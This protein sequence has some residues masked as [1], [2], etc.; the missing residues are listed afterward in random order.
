MSGTDA[1]KSACN[2][3]RHRKI[4]CDRAKPACENCR[5]AGVACLFTAL[6]QRKSPREQLEEAKAQIKQLKETLRLERAGQH[7]SHSSTP[8]APA[9]TVFDPC[10]FETTLA[11]FRWHL[12]FCTPGADPDRR[13]DS[14]L[15]FDAFAHGLKQSLDSPRPIP[16]K[17]ITPKWPSRVVMQ[18]SLEYYESNK[19]YAIFPMVDTMALKRLLDA[20]E[21]GLQGGT[22]DA[23]NQACLTALTAFVT[24]IRHHEPTFTEADSSAYMQAVLSMLPQLVMEHTNIRTL[25]AVLILAVDL[26]PQG[27][28]QTA[29]LLMSLAVR[30]LYN[31]K[32]NLNKP[33]S[34]DPEQVRAHHHLR[35]LFWVCYSIDKEMS[36]RRCQPPIINDADCDLDLPATYVSITSDHQFFHS[37]LS[38]QELLYPTDLRLAVLK[39][40]IYRLLYS[41]LSLRLPESARLQL[42]R[43]LDEE[44]SDLKAQFPAVCQPDMY[45]KGEVSDTL[46]L[47]LSVRGANTHLEYYHCLSK[48][49]GASISGSSNSTMRNLSPPSSSME[50][51]YQASRSTLLY[52]CRTC[53]LITKETFW[54]YAQ[55]ILTAVFA[56]YQRITT[57]SIEYHG[58]EDLR[59]LEKILEVFVTLRIADGE[60]GFPPFAVTEALIRNLISS[61][62]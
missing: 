41:P 62:K 32:G 3:C 52:V 26:A 16:T 58:H 53:H 40:K 21:L 4:R 20:N 2:L 8:A 59:L 30:I 56:L 57:A 34:S 37:S 36:L 54:I 28:P 42:I 22:I 27:Q 6:P 35:A 50:L 29:E 18:Q 11:A 24:R 33:A 49:H 7:R 15:D 13:L 9:L 38:L 61:V 31:L 44:L 19:L 45:A 55:F 10:G 51:C 60:G 43:Q 48:I 25:E 23:A 14:Y 46:L 47:N 39:S 5:L 1:P 12:Q 17:V